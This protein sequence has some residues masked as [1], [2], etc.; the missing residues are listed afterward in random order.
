MPISSQALGI[1]RKN[2]LVVHLH[3][4]KKRIDLVDPLIGRTL[5]STQSF[6]RMKSLIGLGP[7]EYTPEGTPAAFDDL[8]PLFVQDFYPFKVT[9]G[10]KI[11]EETRF[12]DQYNIVKN[13]APRFAKS[14]MD[15]KNITAASLNNLGF[16]S[17][18]MGM[19]SETLYSTGHSNGTGTTNGGNSNRPAVEVAFGPLAV[20]QMKNEMRLQRD[21]RNTP[22]MNNGQVL[23]T[24]PVQLTGNL[25]AVLKSVNLPGTFANDINYAKENVDG[26]VIDWYTSTTAWFARMK[27]NEQLGLFWMDQMPYKMIDLPLDASL[28]WQW[29]A[30]ASYVCGWYGWWGTWGT[31]GA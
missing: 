23:V 29:V 1:A 28:M 18:T 4:M 19:N 15:K 8:Q 17:T 11:T 30:Y 9:K 6:E 14:F 22:L 12:T 2:I 7:A 10:V 25:A 21:A 16:T 31:L 5:N 13:L 3:E 24:V 26:Q 27:D 20:Q